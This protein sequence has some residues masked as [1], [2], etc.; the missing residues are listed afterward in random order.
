[1]KLRSDR[2][3]QIIAKTDAGKPE[4]TSLV[5]RTFRTLD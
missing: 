1:L 4:D 3:K 5:N 2:M